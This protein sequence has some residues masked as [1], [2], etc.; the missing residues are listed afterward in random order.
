MNTV[1]NVYTSNHEVA[2]EDWEKTGDRKRSRE[3]SQREKMHHEKEREI[4]R[5]G[6]PIL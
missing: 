6:D 4:L 1:I 2:L 3:S 5:D